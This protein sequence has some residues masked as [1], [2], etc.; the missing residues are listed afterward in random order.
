MK[1]WADVQAGTGTPIF[2]CDPHSPWQKPSVENNNGILRRWLPKGTP[3]D[4]YTQD[5]LDEIARKIN[6]MPRRI[7]GWR[8]AQQRLR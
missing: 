4:T 5:D 2:F 8:T 3:L 7:H 6:N 1:F